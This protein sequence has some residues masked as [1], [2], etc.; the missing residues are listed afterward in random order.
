MSATNVLVPG[1]IS[2]LT[3]MHRAYQMSLFPLTDC[4]PFFLVI[5]GCFLK[6]VN[7]CVGP[8]RAGFFLAYV[9][10]FSGSIPHCS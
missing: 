4:V 7:L 3:E 1:E 10:S 9:Y 8:L 2:P 6:W 5:L